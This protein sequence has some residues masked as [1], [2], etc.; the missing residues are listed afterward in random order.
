MDENK[1][2][3]QLLRLDRQGRIS[4]LSPWHDGL[5]YEKEELV[6]KK[7]CQLCQD[8]AEVEE[9]IEDFFSQGL[10]ERRFNIIIRVR[11]KS[12]Q[13]KK[14]EKVQ[15]QSQALQMDCH[16]TKDGPGAASG[17]DP[18]IMLA[19][20]RPQRPA[21]DLSRQDLGSME[22]AQLDLEKNK[23]KESWQD[24]Q[25][26]VFILDESLVYRQ[27]Y[28]P[29]GAPI[30]DV[31]PQ[32][33]GLGVED[34]P[35]PADQRH[36][37]KKTMQAVLI[38]RTP[39][40][41]CYDVQVAGQTRYLE[42][43][44]SPFNPELGAGVG[45]LTTIKDVSQ[46]IQT[47]QRL[48]AQ[49][50]QLELLSK[51]APVGIFQLRQKEGDW[52]FD[53]INK[54]ISQLTRLSP[55]DIV[56][57]AG[58]LWEEI[59]VK[60]R[61]TLLEEIDQAAQKKE[62][63][64]QTVR[65][66]NRKE[67]EG[68]RWVT[69]QAMAY[70]E[71]KDLI[72]RGVFIDIHD[73]KLASMRLGLETQRLENIITSTNMGTWEWDLASHKLRYNSRWADMLGYSLEEI[74]HKE[75]FIF[76]HLHP[77]DL[78]QVKLKMEK[79]F[80]R[81]I[82]YYQ[83][84][85][86]LRH[87][88]GH[89][90]WVHS[91]GKVI[92][93]DKEGQPKTIFGTQKD[94]SQEK[95]RDQLMEDKTMEL[96]KFFNVNLDLLCITD[97]EGRFLQ[98]N[99]QWEKTL[100]YSLEELVGSYIHDHIAP[101]DREKTRAAVGRLKKDENV[102][103]FV[104]RYLT[105]A[106]RIRVIEWRSTPYGGKI[107]AAARDITDR[108]QREKALL[109]T[110]Q[111]SE[112]FLSSGQKTLDY[113]AI[114]EKML[115]IC[116]ARLVA[117][118]LYEKDGKRFR[119]AALAGETSV[120][121][122][123]FDLLGFTLIDKVWDYDPV[124]EAKIKGKITHRFNSLEELSDQVIERK[125]ID[126]ISRH[127]SLGETVL[128]KITH[129][130][131]M[132]GDF[133][134]IMDQDRTF[135]QQVVAEIFANLLGL[136]MERQTARRQL[137]DSHRALSLSEDRQRKLIDEM[138][139]GLILFE[140]RPAQKGPSSYRYLQSNQA[141][142]DI[143]GECGKDLPAFVFD[144]LARPERTESFEAYAPS[145]KKHFYVQKYRPQADQVAMLFDD[146]TQRKALAQ[147]RRKVKE[148]IEHISR[149]Q[150]ILLS[151]SSMF[152][153]SSEKDMDQ[154]IEDSLAVL[155]RAVGADRVYIFSY[156][157]D[158]S[159][160]RNT[161]EWCAP[162]VSCQ[163]EDLQAVD[164][165][166]IS[167]LVEAHRQGKALEVRACSEKKESKKGE[168]SKESK[169]PATSGPTARLIAGLG[170][171]SLLT[172]PLYGREP[173]D[174]F[175]GFDAVKGAHRY[176]Q[177]E[178]ELLSRYANQLLHTLYRMQASRE[179]RKSEEKHRFMSDNIGDVLWMMDLDYKLSYVSPS[180]ERVTGFTHKDYLQMPA[181]KRHPQD[182]LEKL[183][184]RVKIEYEKDQEAGVDKDR[185]I[186]AEIE[187][188]T[189]DGGIICLNVN[190][191][192]TRDASGRPSGILGV[193]RDITQ[194]KKMEIALRDSEERFRKIFSE[195]SS[196]GI[197]GLDRNGRVIYWNQASSQLYGYDKN[198]AL[199]E[200][201]TDLIVMPPLRKSL[202]GQLDKMVETGQ[203][204][205]AT[206][207]LMKDK[208]GRSLPVLSNHALV[209]LGDGSRE[210]YRLDIDLTTQKDLEKKLY[211]EK[212]RFQTTL[213][214]VGD[215][216]I[217]TDRSGRLQVINHTG[218]AMTGY[219]AKAALGKDYR[220]I[221]KISQ[222]DGSLLERSIMEEVLLHE[223]SYDFEENF[224][225]TD[226]TGRQLTVQITASP[227]VRG[228]SQTQPQTKPQ[229]LGM[230]VVFRDW[231]DRQRDLDKIEYL[232]Y[233]DHLTGLYNRRYMEELLEKI[234][235]NRAKDVGL[236]YADVNML[237]LT[238]DA[239]GHERGDE[240][241][242]KVA[243]ILKE[244]APARTQTGRVG[245]DEFLMVL[246]N[247]N[248]KALEQIE[249][250]ILSRAD[251]TQVGLLTLSVATG[252][253]LKK[254]TDASIFRVQKLAEDRMY[255]MKTQLG[256]K[257][258]LEA[259]A[260]LQEALFK[261]RPASRKKARI[262]EEKA[263]ALADQLMLSKRDKEELYLAVRF[264][265]IGLTGLLEADLLDPEE[266][267]KHPERGYQILKAVDAYSGVAELV[268]YH[269]ERFDGRGFPEGRKGE[270][271][272]L[273][274]RLLSLLNA[275]YDLAYGPAAKKEKKLGLSASLRAR[276]GKDL[277]PQL[278]EAFILA[279][280]V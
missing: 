193:S 56:R 161:H 122:R 50:A 16:L 37:I 124:R 166:D 73:N 1:Q 262:L 93:W 92:V 20:F 140:E 271:I 45:I 244:S 47:R 82:E 127:F 201:L 97:L 176:G 134:I 111:A 256:K 138:K 280:Q 72:Y 221:F 236:V 178:E 87:K 239:F 139:Q 53:Y 207:Q 34:L 191:S 157:F 180:V 186:R 98:M 107:Y 179:L 175:V 32:I 187:H 215:G 57:S 276:G 174:G 168:E 237:K 49:K 210:I 266:I 61:A 272:P 85:I 75:S 68:Y 274:S 154:T 202:Q 149:I 71:E 54:K 109:K 238:N 196:V 79:L 117:F 242:I 5:G 213:M 6:G 145:L 243:H 158:Q 123:A 205:P 228:Q 212:E 125:T 9:Q 84:E 26:A 126:F 143:L 23:R 277:D 106:G 259:V 128:V 241:L 269:H 133:T 78:D 76:D 251:Q 120:L 278:V 19:L 67:K 77:Q 42:Q 240:L 155:G 156:D 15:S 230:V 182:S 89:Y 2:I 189:R 14:G 95:K 248:L 206:T 55:K 257:V 199:G 136:A 232:S 88:D 273:L 190:A 59:H 63:F 4:W 48:E 142:I 110:V 263:Q 17:L 188:Y 214:S 105:K 36:K 216:I 163:K 130:Q 208:A 224:I 52:S 80:N 220:Q 209:D 267:K 81:E 192:I 8:P 204:L 46:E 90:I 103:N 24:W 86:R 51:E 203:T 151:V 233:H 64:R 108:H 218:Q 31:L 261:D 222:E 183:F 167:D 147:E 10:E 141:C 171:K 249:K 25:T 173:V 245:G 219:G 181:E 115:D 60:D 164:L 235:A 270:D 18:Q 226:R 94:I 116:Q 150:R 38:D 172:V 100:G 121:D 200:K 39:T 135:N 43:V 99:K 264:Q 30:R 197:Q 22:L 275:Y 66:L 225:L 11:E 118:N 119:T 152:I 265:D 65:L 153:R 132:L 169:E 194:R 96:E 217:A 250:E 146:I 40:M 223:K 148:R 91:H 137:A 246:T 268:L 279:G 129:N 260:D 258:R 255:R 198:Q 21:L 7:F 41:L 101:E 184:S 144:W 113:Q 69:F 159:I 70:Q 44:I 28:L 112:D 177:E 104:N 231:T 83:Q 252:S 170:I 74:G 35:L 234:D 33:V 114:T 131:T 13:N 229:I 195:V 247:T 185:I 211:E 162:G 227:I 165:T 160:A 62:A 102:Y 27:A 12:S 3:S 58:V 253:A 254:E 29:Q